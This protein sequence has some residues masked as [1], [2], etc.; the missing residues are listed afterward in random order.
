MSKT[1]SGKGDIAETKTQQDMRQ[2]AAQLSTAKPLSSRQGEVR[3]S[4][5]ETALPVPRESG[6]SDGRGS[7]H[8]SRG[9]AQESRSRTV[10]VLAL[11]PLL[12]CS[13][14]G[15]RGVVTEEA[16]LQ[17]EGGRKVFFQ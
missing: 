4:R 5:A 1:F 2:E 16:E 14:I 10:L 6:S 8:R 15:R 7:A 11:H 12:C 13:G 3:G 17:E 9:T